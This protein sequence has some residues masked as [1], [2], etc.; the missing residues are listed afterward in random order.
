MAPA[1]D[2]MAGRALWVALRHSHISDEMASLAPRAFSRAALRA[3]AID[4]VSG[5]LKARVSSIDSASQ[6]VSSAFTP[7]T[8][9][10]ARQAASSSTDGSSS[11]RWTWT[12][13]MRAVSSARST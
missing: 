2:T 1:R 8:P 9:R 3:P 12:S 11:R 13:R 4:V 6:G 5:V 10:T 7:M